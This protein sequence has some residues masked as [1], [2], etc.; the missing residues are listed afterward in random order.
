[1]NHLE[2]H[3]F[4]LLRSA[5]WDT[6]P[7]LSR[8]LSEKEWNDIYAISKE[9]TVSGIMIDAI[10]KLPEA[11]KPPIKLRMQWIMLQKNIE[12][13]NAATNALLSSLATTLTQRGI[14][15]YLLKGQGV[16]LNYPTP[17]HRI[18]GDIDL[19]FLP[20]QF[21]KA[22]DFF[23]ALGCEIEDNSEDSHAETEYNG[24]KIEL[25]KKSASYYT[26]KLQQRYN[27]IT[28]NI[29][30]KEQAIALINGTKIGVL[31][32]MANA[33]Q[34]LSHMLR[35][36]IFS[37]LGLRQICDWVLFIHKHHSNINKEQFLAY[38]KELQLLET[39]KAITAIAIDYLG[40]PSQCAMCDITPKDKQLAKKVLNL[41]MTYGNFGQYGEHS[42]TGTKK[43]YLRA[44]IWKVKNCFR[45]RKLAGS[46]AWSYPL[47][48]LHTIGKM[49]K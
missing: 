30:A 39:Y 23:N 9:Q 17:S 48:Q 22:M 34:L 37:G 46:E 43:E 6:T 15:T 32:P 16:A 1:M 5:I 24:I 40:L 36:I 47:W 44:Y 29:L 10:A 33:F 13:R 41:V 49:A 19:F 18:C 2:E 25:H 7:Q 12:A 27:T 31:P 26:R 28:G 8:N 21:S 42:I 38:A 14:R 35:H 45:F 4:T 11:Q 3:F 20:N